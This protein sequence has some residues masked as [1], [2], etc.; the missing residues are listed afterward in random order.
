MTDKLSV[1]TVLFE[2]HGQKYKVFLACDKRH[3]GCN[4]LNPLYFL[5]A[6]RHFET[7][8]KAGYHG[9]DVSPVLY[10]GIGYQEGVDIK[11]ARTFDYTVSDG[12]ER[13]K[14]GGG[15]E[16]FYRFIQDV[17]KPWVEC[18]FKVN[19]QMQT[20][21]GHSFGGHFTLY[22]AFHHQTAFQRYVA[23]SPALWWANGAVLPEG[24][25]KLAA[26]I[27]W[28]S[29]LLGSREERAEP[30]STDL[31]KEI[32]QRIGDNPRLNVRNLASQ[33]VKDGERCSF[34]FLPGRKHPAVAKD[35]ARIANFV[36]S[37]K[38]LPTG[39]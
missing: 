5:D 31:E 28:L 33:L 10:I 27:D 14:D 25:V 12:S 19:K 3:V 29:L 20:L 9:D 16:Q 2:Y 36:A 18:R 21:A 34:E 38:P 11:A 37:Q 7:L 4:E 26:S 15:A 39:L 8:I 13:F 32:F 22:V 17:V 6:N 24:D 30:D 1:Q 23:A 35:Y